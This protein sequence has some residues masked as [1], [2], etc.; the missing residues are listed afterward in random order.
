[1]VNIVVIASGEPQTLTVDSSSATVNF[2]G[3]PNQSYDVQRST[4]LVDWVTIGTTNAP[5]GGLFNF[6]DTFSDLGGTEPA[7]AYYRLT[8][9]Q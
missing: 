5:P 8:W 1:M 3:Q 6:M 2:S 4:N 9:S 7:A